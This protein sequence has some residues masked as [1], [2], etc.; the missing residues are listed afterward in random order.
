MIGGFQEVLRSLEAGSS[1]VLA[2]K[3]MAQRV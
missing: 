1:D 3:I 2:G